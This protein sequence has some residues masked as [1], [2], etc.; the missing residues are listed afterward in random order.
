MVGV[1]SLLALSREPA[2]EAGRADSPQGETEVER[3]QE[4]DARSSSWS[5]GS[6]LVSDGTDRFSAA[7]VI[8]GLTN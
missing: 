6:T 1:L 3:I 7:V 5:H 8:E 4:D 2:C